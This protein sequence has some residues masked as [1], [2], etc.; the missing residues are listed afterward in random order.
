M[1]REHICAKS[2]PQQLA[3]Q[4][5]GKDLATHAEA[6]LLYGCVARTGHACGHRQSSHDMQLS[7][8]TGAVVAAAAAGCVLLV[9]IF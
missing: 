4:A 1:C 3:W 5:V 2:M 9:G 8:N 7:S 6:Q